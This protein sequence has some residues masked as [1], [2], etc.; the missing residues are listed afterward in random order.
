MRSVS[1]F[2]CLFGVLLYQPLSAG[3]SERREGKEI[4]IR[5]S[6]A[7]ELP[8]SAGVRRSTPDQIPFQIEWILDPPLLN[9]GDFEVTADVAFG[10]PYY[11]DRDYI[12]LSVNPIL[13][14]GV[15][16]RTYN[17]MKRDSLVAAED[18]DRWTCTV[19]IDTP[20]V[21]Y[22]LWDPLS[23]P[24]LPGW[25]SLDVWSVTGE[26]QPTTD[27]MGYFDI[28]RAFFRAREPIV[29]GHHQV[30]EL[31]PAYVPQSMYVAVFVPLADERFPSGFKLWPNY[32]N[33]FNTRTE[34]RYSTLDSRYLELAIFNINGQKVRTLVSR[35]HLPGIYSAVWDGKDDRGVPLASGVYYCR[36]N[37]AFQTLLI[38]T[39]LVR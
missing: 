11:L 26:E 1:M 24:Y 8:S 38:K 22:L 3:I 9:G 6:I 13:S 27:V 23:A 39:A 19:T 36:L 5:S 7:A 20:V 37:S 31:P 35:A 32:P 10:T 17:D 2:I 4:T 34:I 25:L 33:P 15:L 14:S 28:F 30:S 29:L 21:A 18:R 12:F 16:L